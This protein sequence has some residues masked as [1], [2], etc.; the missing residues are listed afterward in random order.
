MQFD[1]GFLAGVSLFAQVCGGQM[2]WGSACSGTDSPK[3]VLNPLSEV[4]AA[5]GVCLQF[6]HLFSVEIEAS[7]F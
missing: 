4:L 7:Y 5:M 1:P 2:Q 6:C 3:W